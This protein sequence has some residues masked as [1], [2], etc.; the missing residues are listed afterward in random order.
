MEEIKRFFPRWVFLGLWLG[1][2]LGGPA[3]AQAGPVAFAPET[4]FEFPPLFDGQE[5]RHGFVIQNKG[6]APLDILEVRT[7]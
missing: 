1:W 2:G 5:A 4:C 3:L 6:T 7:G